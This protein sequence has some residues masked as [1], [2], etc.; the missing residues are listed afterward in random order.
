MDHMQLTQLAKANKKLFERYEIFPYG[1]HYKEKNIYFVNFF[2]I[3]PSVSSGFLFI[4]LDLKF[5]I[6]IETFFHFISM[7]NHLNHP[8]KSSKR[9]ATYD[10][11][12]SVYNY[13]ELLI[14]HQN[15][16]QIINSAVE[17]CITNINQ[18][19]DLFEIVLKEIL[20]YEDKLEKI[21]SI[22]TFTLND[23]E[24]LDE[25]SAV[26][27]YYLYQISNLQMKMV[28]SVA[29][30]AQSCKRELK[31]KAY[32]KELNIKSLLI[33]EPKRVARLTN[34]NNT[35][36]PKQLEGLT[37]E[38]QIKSFVRSRYEGIQFMDEAYLK[39]KIRNP[40][41]KEVEV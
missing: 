19:E 35:F 23:V 1:Y 24:D 38:E 16:L 9:L 28:D 29:I 11:S 4:P 41:I 7:E 2:R 34:N 8:F 15:D 26:I 12:K 13:R 17:K 39:R 36:K 40:S 18:I 22:K 37:K 31:E 20:M 14:K 27:D 32:L 5:E 10:Y 25:K 33:L 21:K 30:I 6:M 3:A